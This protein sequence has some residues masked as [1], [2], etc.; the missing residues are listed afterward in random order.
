MTTTQSQK[1]CSLYYFF[2]SS[3]D[4]DPEQI[5]AS[6]YTPSDRN[7]SEIAVDINIVGREIGSTPAEVFDFSGVPQSLICFS[8]NLADW[9]EPYGEVR[10][11]PH[12]M[13]NL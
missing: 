12:A 10:A 1:P 3:S 11:F 7:L 8:L 6:Y 4:S 9:S 13:N 5:P 2:V